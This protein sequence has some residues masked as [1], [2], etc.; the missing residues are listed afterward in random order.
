ME[1][2]YYFNEPL[3]VLK[4]IYKNWLKSNGKFVMGID[5]YYENTECHD[6]Q[7]KTG[8]SIMKLMSIEDWEALF[9][10]AGFNNIKK[11]QFCKSGNWKGTL[12]IEGIKID[13]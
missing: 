8:V 7:E 11:H 4:N 5:F 1:V 6:W 10:L 2:L 13:K 3:L 9:L 12:V